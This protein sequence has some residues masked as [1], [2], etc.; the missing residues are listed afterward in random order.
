MSRF[1]HAVRSPE[2]IE[3]KGTPAYL[4]EF[5]GTLVLVLAITGLVSASAVAGLSLTNLALVHALALMGIVYSI[6]TI[7]G[8]HVNP[9]VTLGLLTIRK[10]S[11]R[12]AGIYIV[13]QLL[14]GLAGAFL[15]K[16]FFLGRGALVNYGTPGISDRYLQ[17]GSV[18]LAFLA[19]AIGAFLIVWAVMGTAVNPTAPKG[20]AGAAIGGS[21]ALGVLIFAPATGASFNPARWFGPAL[22]S[23]TWT[24]A[25]MYILAPI[26]GGIA[27]ALSYRMIMELSQIPAQTARRGESVEQPPIAAG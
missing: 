11:G 18:G 22:A 12:D 2:P 3:D 4:A 21:L 8:A 23:G 1:S 15:A 26:V 10:I 9:A 24:D 19:E 25:W 16:A 13:M 20:V 27:A 14:G 17:G 6:G 5:L 7:S